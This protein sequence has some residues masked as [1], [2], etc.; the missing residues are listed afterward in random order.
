MNLTLL[1]AIMIG[2]AVILLAATLVR[3]GKKLS[4]SFLIGVITG[5]SLAVVPFIWDW[6]MPLL[7]E[8][9]PEWQDTILPIAAIAL[10]AIWITLIAIAIATK[11]RL[12]ARSRRVP[13]SAPVTAPKHLGL[14]IPPISNGEMSLSPDP[15]G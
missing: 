10:P 3:S 7:S 4:L 5:I 12:P 9:W 1:I 2:G 14:E 11:V 13:T 15:F 8:K 6:S